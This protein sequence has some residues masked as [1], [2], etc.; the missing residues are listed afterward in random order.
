M[1]N[2]FRALV[3]IWLTSNC[4]SLGDDVVL[5]NRYVATYM[6]VS[7]LDLVFSQRVLPPK[8]PTAQQVE[9]LK[10]RDPGARYATNYVRVENVTRLVNRVTA[11]T[12]DLLIAQSLVYDYSGHI[13]SDFQILASLKS[14]DDLFILYRYYIY[15]FVVRFDSRKFDGP[16]LAIRY[17]VPEATEA[18][19]KNLRKGGNYRRGH[20]ALR[21]PNALEIIL[22]GLGTERQVL[23]KVIADIAPK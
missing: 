10:V 15:Y 12:N 8:T 20:L 3:V 19:A 17:L 2:H 22:D 4:A 11:R 13:P 6:V 23:T 7:N 16:S 5:T 18:V 9:A 14:G 21:A 1:S